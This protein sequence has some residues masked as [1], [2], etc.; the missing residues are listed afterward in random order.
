MA[1]VAED[2]Q[3]R[4]AAAQF[5]RNVPLGEV[6]VYLFIVAAE[7]AVDSTQTFQTC[8]A[9]T[10]QS[11]DPQLKIRIHGILD[12]YRDINTFQCIGDFLYG[13]RVGSGTCAYPKNI[14]SGFQAF[15]NVLGSSYFSRNIHSC[16][17][18][19]F[20]QPGK[21]LYT[22]SFETSR[23]GTWFPDS[24]TEYFLSFG[25]QLSGGIHYLFFSL[26]ATWAGDDDWSF[27]FYAR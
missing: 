5:D 8:I 25:C 2:R 20:F 13:E 7:T 27:G 21:T 26:C 14:D 17:L 18:L 11:S 19:H 12:Q 1:R 6:A 3:I 9:D 23:F 4:N 16:F 15:V 22:D 24:G 10:F